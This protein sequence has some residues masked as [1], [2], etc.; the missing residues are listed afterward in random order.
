[1]TPGESRPRGVVCAAVPLARVPAA[2][3]AGGTMDCPAAQA[4]VGRRAL[5]AE[6]RGLMDEESG[7]WGT[8]HNRSAEPRR[9]A[10]EK[11]RKQKRRSVARSQGDTV[12]SSH[13]RGPRPGIRGG[14]TP[15]SLCIAYARRGFREAPPVDHETT[16]RQLN[17]PLPHDRSAALWGCLPNSRTPVTAFF[18]PQQ[19]GVWVNIVRTNR[20]CVPPHG[21]SIRIRLRFFACRRAMCPHPTPAGRPTPMT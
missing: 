19:V 16:R 11:G 4:A 10:G 7:G 3:G 5:I 14:R 9:Q 6:A 20:L 2:A 21:V 18:I 15:D 17:A 13:G 8:G 12:E 1:M